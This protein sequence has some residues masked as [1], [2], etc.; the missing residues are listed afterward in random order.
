MEVDQQFLWRLAMR[1]RPP[2]ATDA[3]GGAAQRQTPRW[4]LLNR[5]AQRVANKMSQAGQPAPRLSFLKWKNLGE[6]HVLIW[7]KSHG[8]LCQKEALFWWESQPCPALHVCRGLFDHV[9]SSWD[10]RADVISSQ[11]PALA[12]FTFTF[13]FAIGLIYVL[14]FNG[15]LATS[16][17]SIW[18]LVPTIRRYLGKGNQDFALLYLL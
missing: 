6:Y 16:T 9:H 7:R 15:E 14:V 10:Y 12:R 17:C 11:F 18:Q 2:G 8:G 5:N 3:G 1:M 13:I 4:V